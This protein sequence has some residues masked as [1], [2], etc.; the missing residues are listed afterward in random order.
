MITLHEEITVPRSIE[1]CFRY[2]A[3]FRKA[4]EWDATAT[5]ADKV[6]DG[7]IG[8]GTCFDLDCAVGPGSIRL[9]Y[10]IEEFQPWH[11]LV[12]RG[13]G[14]YFDV[15]DTIVFSERP[16]GTHIDYTAN[17]HYRPGLERIATR[18]ERGMRAMGAASLAGLRRAL[19]DNNPLPQASAGVT[20]ADQWVLPG[21]ALFTRWGYQRGRRHWLP[22][23]RF[24]D[25]KHVVITGASSGLGLASAL[26]LA[27]AGATLTLVIRDPAKEA[28]LRSRIATETGRDDIAIEL[29]D[30]ALIADTQAVATRLLSRGK[31][32][33]VLINNAGA[34]F[35]DYGE[36]REALERSFALLLVSPWLLTEQLQPL[37][38]DH[39]EPARVINVVSGGMYTERL[40]CKRLVMPPEHYQ[41]ARAYARAKR[42]L[43]VLTEQWAT[44]WAD[45]NIVVNAMHP[46]WADTPGVATALPTFKKLT[47]KV[48]R[49]AKEG[50][51]TIIWLAQAREAGE[52]SGK[53]FLDR[54]P[55]TP[56]LLEKTREAPAERDALLDL[57]TQTIDSVAAKKS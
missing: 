56:Y 32:V 49:D 55:R 6:T 19:E 13:R 39:S 7:P 44:R 42:G 18:F 40:N 17:F 41:G 22:V 35:N 26:A 24:M 15:V 10:E 8:T 51:D 50:A 54:E 25:G 34:L 43:M 12:L 57:L 31:P 11:S 38:A 30:L 45:D 47:Q 27:E 46:G 29:A 52:L 3:D 5:R 2:V 1:D 37:L 16:D 48:L 14:R 23:S 9:L 28:E 20:R 4:V 36:T 53:L 21:V 33:D